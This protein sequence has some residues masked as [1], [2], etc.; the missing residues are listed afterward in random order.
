MSGIVIAALCAVFGVWNYKV[1]NTFLSGFLTGEAVLTFG[2][3]LKG[4]F[5]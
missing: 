2:I 5:L 4:L 3:A 1:G